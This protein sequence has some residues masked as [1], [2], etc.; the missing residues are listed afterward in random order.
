MKRI[1]HYQKCYFRM[2]KNI[3]ITLSKLCFKDSRVNSTVE[4]ND[5]D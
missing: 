1:S 5:T 2:T 4:A 3:V